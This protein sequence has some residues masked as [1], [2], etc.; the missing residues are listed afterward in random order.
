MPELM[1]AEE[2]SR[3]LSLET[4]FLLRVEQTVV[5]SHN[6]VKLQIPLKCPLKMSTL[7]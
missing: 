6:P 1:G 3:F 2:G 4:E 7:I 5:K